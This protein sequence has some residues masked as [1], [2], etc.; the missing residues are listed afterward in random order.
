MMERCIASSDEPFKYMW[1]QQVWVLWGVQ[2]DTDKCPCSVGG[3]DLAQWLDSGIWQ[4]WKVVGVTKSRLW[5]LRTGVALSGG[6]PTPPA[7]FLSGMAPH[8]CQNQGEDTGFLVNIRWHPPH[9]LCWFTCSLYVTAPEGILLD[10][11]CVGGGVQ[12]TNL[13]GDIP[14]TE[15]TP[16]G[17]ESAV[18]GEIKTNK[19]EELLQEISSWSSI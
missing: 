1:W 4:T 2:P 17:A 16:R 7:S 15:E 19:V 18:P 8:D 14:I 9:K 6:M 5:I 11:V 3:G 12:K 13:A 10:R